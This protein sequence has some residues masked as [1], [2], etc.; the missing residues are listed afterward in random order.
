MATYESF[1]K[2][3][4]S[5]GDLV[6]YNLNGKN[7]VRKK[8][9]FNKTAY[10]KSPTYEK[11]RQNSSEFG[12]CSKIGK[13]IR[14]CISKYI[15]LADEALLYQR[16]AKTMTK[17][18]DLD[19]ENEKGKRSVKNG[20]KTKEGRVILQQFEF[21]DISNFNQ[22]TQIFLGLWDKSLHLDKAIFADEVAIVS[23]KIDFENYLT[24]SF[25]EKIKLQ[26]SQNEVIFE[27]HFS[28]EDDEIHFVAVKR[29][30]HV[31]QMG[32]V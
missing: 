27:N 7:I 3:N 15:E 9:G 16:F 12:H 32:F 24:E 25:E 29:D 8:S 28:E 18:K 31:V 20:L 14:S 4:G 19:I 10:K 2:L 26:E 30:S 21:G 5:I 1:I 13:L 22:N 23:I 17:I 11:V 6:F